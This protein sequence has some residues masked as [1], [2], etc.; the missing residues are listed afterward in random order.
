MLNFF[1]SLKSSDWTDINEQDYRK[2]WQDFGGSV[3][4][5]PDVVIGLSQLADIPL[6]F[7]AHLQG[8]ELLAAVPVWD[9]HIALSK[10]VLNKQ[11]KRHFFDLGNAEIIFPHQQNAS[12]ALPY[13]GQY[14]SE[15]HVPACTT[16]HEQKEGLALARKPED[17]SRK[18]RYNQRRELRLFEEAGGFLKP[19]SELSAEQQAQYYISLFEKRWQ[20][21]TPA[22]DYLVPVLEIMRPFVVG[23]YAELE[24][25]AVAYQVLYRV[26]AKHWHS[27]EYING[28]VDPA[29]N[30]LSP[31]SILSFANTQA[32]WEYA[33]SQNKELRYSFGRADRE[34]KDRWC[35]R[36]SVFESR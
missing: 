6:S 27:V 7:K 23:Y 2:A 30:E 5:H 11:K 14:I 34:Y 13:K 22:K 20:F 25:Q 3:A 26:E 4:T 10:A 35:H 31:G 33:R 12:I 29:C 24:G 18:F 15:F 36:V 17:Y 28:G 21:D 32:E 16:L 19:V 1:R 8:D 9:K